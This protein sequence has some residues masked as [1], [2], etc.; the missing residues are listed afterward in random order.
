[1]DFEVKGRNCDH[2]VA[3]GAKVL[4]LLAGTAWGTTDFYVEMFPMATSSASAAPPRHDH[5]ERSA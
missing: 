1:M 5:T 2:C 3:K 4:K